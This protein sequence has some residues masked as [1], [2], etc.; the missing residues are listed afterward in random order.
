MI[1]IETN[2]FTRLLPKY[3]TDDDYSKLQSFLL[4]N[5]DAGNLSTGTGGLRKLR[6]AISNRGKRGG[7]RIIYYWQVTKKHIYFMTLYA[8]NEMSDLSAKDKQI[9]KQLIVEI[10]EV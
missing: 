10:E 1:F 9:L 3:L 7:I 6:W 5:P 4:E 8:K 2:L